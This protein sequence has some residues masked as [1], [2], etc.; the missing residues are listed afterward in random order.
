MKDF[1]GSCGGIVSA[2]IAKDRETNKSR[3]FGHIDFENTDAVKKALELAGNDFNGRPVKVDVALPR[4][5]GG[6]RGGRGGSRGGRGGAGSNLSAN[7]RAA[8]KGN[9]VAF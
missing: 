9:I 3:G 1:F 4:T 2:R 8:K 6:D 7:D 5:G